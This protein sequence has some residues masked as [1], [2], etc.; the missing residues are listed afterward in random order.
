MSGTAPCQANSWMVVPSTT[1][2]KERSPTDE[3][4]PLFRKHSPHRPRHRRRDC[5]VRDGH[6]RPIRRSCRRWAALHLSASGRAS[7]LRQFRRLSDR[8][9]GCRRTFAPRR[10][11]MLGALLVSAL[12][13]GAMAAGFSFHLPA[14]ALPRRFRQ[15]IRASVHVIAVLDRL[16]ETGRGHM[17]GHQF[18]ASA[19]HRDLRCPGVSWPRSMW[20]GSGNGWPA[21]F[22]CPGTGSRR[23]PHPAPAAQRSVRQRSNGTRSAA[24]SPRYRGLW[25]V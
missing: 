19:P 1:M 10:G 9:A 15:R 25:P 13:T 16:S 21:R 5:F 24:R 12:T 4:Y 18:A 11:W 2:T 20:R 8:R 7:S 6:G 23:V 22:V 3:Q 14:A 17:A